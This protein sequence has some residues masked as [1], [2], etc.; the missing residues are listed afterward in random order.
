M[1]RKMIC[2]FVCMPIFVFCFSTETLAADSVFTE[3]VDTAEGP[4]VGLADGQAAACVWKGRDRGQSFT[5]HITY[6][7]NV[8]F[9][10]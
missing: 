8:I 2:L 6:L 1:F 9:K 4:V 10:G 5:L 7:H 3:P